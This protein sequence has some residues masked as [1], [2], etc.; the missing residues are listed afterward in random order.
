MKTA[1]QSKNPPAVLAPGSDHFGYRTYRAKKGSKFYSHFGFPYQVRG[2]RQEANETML[3]S[4]LALRDIF[5]QQAR[6][7]SRCILF[8]GETISFEASLVIYIYI[9]IYI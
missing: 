6:P 7:T 5:R 9:Y 3:Y 4:Q 1:V 2:R 8:D